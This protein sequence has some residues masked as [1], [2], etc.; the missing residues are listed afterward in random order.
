M[1]CLIRW[2]HFLRVNLLVSLLI[3]FHVEAGAYI[4]LQEDII[5]PECTEELSSG[6][7]QAR[8]GGKGIVV[9]F[10][11][12]TCKS[13]INLNDELMRECWEPLREKMVIVPVHRLRQKSCADPVE[14]FD[15]SAIVL[16]NYLKQMFYIEMSSS[17][18][19][20]EKKWGQ[21]LR[22]FNS[23]LIADGFGL[24]TRD[25]SLITATIATIW[26]GFLRKFQV[27]WYGEGVI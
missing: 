25:Q 10:F 4:T 23:A 18:Q 6:I 7:Q 22:E 9:E 20:V 17:G 26:N 11:S 1:F 24:I 21:L 2:R 16:N 5:L 19:D 13:C 14:D 12:L 15:F 27:G 3:A 8:S